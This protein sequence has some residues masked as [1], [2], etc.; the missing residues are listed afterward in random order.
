MK[1]LQSF[2]LTAGLVVAVMAQDRVP[3]KQRPIAPD[4]KPVTVA[5]A[6]EIFRQ[7]EA[8]IRPILK[9]PAGSTISASSS[10][11]PVTREEVIGMMAQ[12]REIVR[13][14]LKVFPYPAKYEKSRFVVKGSALNQLEVLVR[15]GFVSDVSPLSTGKLP[16]TTRSFGDTIGY[17]LARVCDLGHMPNSIWS[18]Y[19]QNPTK[20]H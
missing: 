11:V 20:D 10:T 6:H 7:A 9:L 8:L 3:M 1:V 17:F 5:E 16:L 14:E 4:S 2:L 18:P 13:P 15:E 19:L 12:F